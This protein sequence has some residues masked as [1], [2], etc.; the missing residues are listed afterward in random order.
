[1][2]TPESLLKMDSLEAIKQVLLDNL[3]AWV[4][5]DWLVIENIRTKG[6][7]TPKDALAE[8]TFSSFYAPPAIHAKFTAPLTFQFRRLNLSEFLTGVPRTVKYKG[9]ISSVDI[10]ARLLAAYDIP[11]NQQDVTLFTTETAGNCVITASPNSPRWVGQATLQLIREAYLLKEFFKNTSVFIPFSTSFRSSDFLSVLLK[12]IENH[13]SSYEEPYVL[14]A[15]DF[16]ITAGPTVIEPDDD[17]LNTRIT[18]TGTGGTFAGSLDFTYQRKSYTRTF[19]HPVQVATGGVVTRAKVLDAINF[20]YDTGLIESDI[21]NWSTLPASHTTADTYRLTTVP[22]SFTTVGDIYV[23][24][25]VYNASNQIDLGTEIPTDLMDGFVLPFTCKM[26][27]GLIAENKDLDGFV[28][29]FAAPD[30][31]VCTTKPYLDGFF[32]DKPLL[33]SENTQEPYLDGFTSDKRPVIDELLPIPYLD[34][35]ESNK[36]LLIA[37]QLPVTRLDGWDGKDTWRIDQLLA[38]T[39][40]DGF[41][42]NKRKPL[43]DVLETPSLDGWD[44]A[45]GIPL[46]GMLTKTELQGFDSDKKLGLGDLLEQTKLDGWDYHETTKSI[47]ELFDD[48]QLDGFDSDKKIRLAGTLHQTKLNGFDGKTFRKRDLAEVLTNLNVDGLN[49]PEQ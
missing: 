2:S 27:L 14:K 16:R 31:S 23:E 22:G 18:L 25:V 36:P 47:A 5:K 20:K 48:T 24:L 26:E 6:T 41:K 8:M 3:P 43:S 19:R 28:P 46:S 35:F 32:S 4:E 17:G 29:P 33:I 39:S 21:A 30:V 40:L 1:M 38:T 12:A 13:N 15:T 42:S 45:K 37:E 11:V 44:F 10:L 49:Y 34:G 9:S 7:S